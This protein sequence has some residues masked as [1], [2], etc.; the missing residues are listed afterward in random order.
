[1]RES[2]AASR[3]SRR[4]ARERAPRQVRSGGTAEL[5]NDAVVKSDGSIWFNDPSYGIDYAI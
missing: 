1:V 2:R 3:A 5:A 4:P